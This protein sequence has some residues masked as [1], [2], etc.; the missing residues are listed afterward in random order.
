MLY[1]PP[2]SQCIKLHLL[3]S[4][5][6]SPTEL[7]LSSP[8]TRVFSFNAMF[9]ELYFRCLKGKYIKPVNFFHL[10]KAISN[11]S[12]QSLFL[13]LSLYILHIDLINILLQFF[14]CKNNSHK[15]SP[16]RSWREVVGY[17][18]KVTVRYV[19]IPYHCICIIINI[20]LL[21]SFPYCVVVI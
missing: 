2:F 10:R 14:Y 1:I 16:E 19:F 3:P 7:Y 11:Y 6:V 21:V 17:L 8:I 13:I 4:E 20:C 5:S 9:L 18:T 12:T 15:Y